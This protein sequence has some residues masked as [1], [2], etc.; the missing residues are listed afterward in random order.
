MDPVQSLWKFQNLVWNGLILYNSVLNFLPLTPVIS[1]SVPPGHTSPHPPLLP[2][3]ATPPPYFC[4][5]SPLNFTCPFSCSFVPFK[6]NF[7]SEFFILFSCT[8]SLFT[9]HVLHTTALMQYPFPRCP[10]PFL[11]TF[12]YS[13]SLSMGIHV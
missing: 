3:I 4:I 10:A 11:Y 6:C 5:I 7:C 2:S 1:D 8:F 12:S 13:K 9:L